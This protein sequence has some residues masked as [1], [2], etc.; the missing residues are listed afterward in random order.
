MS[1]T[2]NEW[3]QVA[4]VA[5]LEVL[6]LAARGVAHV[7]RDADPTLSRLVVTVTNLDSPVPFVEVEYFGPS[8][9]PLGGVAL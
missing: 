6:A 4:H 8:S 5:R 2:I 9:V 1:L 7:E 3:Q